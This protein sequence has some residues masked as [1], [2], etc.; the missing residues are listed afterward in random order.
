MRAVRDLSR[1]RQLNDRNEVCTVKQETVFNL[2]LLKAER[3]NR[4]LLAFIVA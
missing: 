4:W 2:I 3:N 1:H